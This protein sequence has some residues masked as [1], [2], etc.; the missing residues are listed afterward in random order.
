MIK[1][2]CYMQILALW[3]VLMPLAFARAVSVEDVFDCVP[4]PGAPF[5]VVKEDQGGKPHYSLVDRRGTVV[6]GPVKGWS[7]WSE[8]ER[9]QRNGYRID[10][11]HERYVR[12]DGV[13]SL[14]P[15][16]Y[17]GALYDLLVEGLFRFHEEGKIG[18][19][20]E[21]MERI[22]PA[23]FDYA[24]NFRGGW[25]LVCLDCDVVLG[26]P[27]RFPNTQGRW[28]LINQS[29][30]MYE[31]AWMP[32]EIAKGLFD[33]ISADIVPT[34]DPYTD[35]NY[36]LV[37]SDGT[38]FYVYQDFGISG[39]LDEDGNWLIYPQ[40]LYN[41]GGWEGT[42][43]IQFAGYMID[44]RGEYRIQPHRFDNGI[45]SLQEGLFRFIEG[46][47]MGYADRCLNEVIP[48]I[49]DGAR[50]FKNGSAIVCIDCVTR[51]LD[52]YTVLEGGRWGAID[53]KGHVIVP[54]DLPSVEAVR[55]RL[56]DLRR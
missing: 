14:S 29:G 6:Q 23:Q 41:F 56:Q 4:L 5:S 3:L 43:F 10:F 53:K 12:Y 35:K 32:F 36:S 45:D 49:Y 18:F 51:P 38:P 22:I 42:Q 30:N 7:D 17:P 50:Q 37:R 25:S 21:C 27:Q 28:N 47:K 26:A 16:F 44:L 20:N 24:S 54:I 11:E 33:R 52:E 34:C 40:L 15:L 55:Q 48:A 13:P 1:V 39:V 46:G 19:A 31:S 2:V 8:L 9:Y